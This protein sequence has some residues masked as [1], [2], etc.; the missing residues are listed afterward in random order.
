MVPCEVTKA[1]ANACH[2]CHG[3]V[4]INGAPMPLV[5]MEDFHVL[6]VGGMPKIPKYQVALMRMDGRRGPPMPPATSPITDEDK[7]TLIDWFSSGA[8]AA[9]GDAN[10]CM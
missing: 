6:S 7:K 1:L 3:P 2:R 4:P 5:V 10:T 8:P 9:T